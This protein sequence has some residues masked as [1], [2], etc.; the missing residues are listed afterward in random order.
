MID[1]E[2]R[3][4]LQARLNGSRELLLAA[5]GDVTERD[6]ATDVGT[7]PGSETVI[8]LIAHL[9]LEESRAASEALGEV[10]ATRDV[11]RP[12]PPQVIHALAGARYRTVRYIESPE[13]DAVIATGL[14]DSVEA[15]ER[16]AAARIA[17]RPPL[18]PLP[19]S[20]QAPD[21]PMIPPEQARR[22]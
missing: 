8:Q 14:V 1:D 4:E 16:D 15:R 2:T 3:Q 6:F 12:M 20:E 17:A 18:P 13:A 21:I 7:T 10:Y 22:A 5:L 11:E 9:A 19:T